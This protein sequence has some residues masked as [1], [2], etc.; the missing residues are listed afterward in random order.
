MLEAAA[1]H[2]RVGADLLLESVLDAV[3]IGSSRGGA[4]LCGTR[5][6][7][8]SMA[9]HTFHMLHTFHTFHTF[10]AF[11]KHSIRS[12]RYLRGVAF[13]RQGTQV[14]LPQTPTRVV[15]SWRT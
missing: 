8:R 6:A 14:L 13:S 4:Q 5:A 10:H 7:W 1:R 15:A 3:T 12:T 9:F 2:E 11:H